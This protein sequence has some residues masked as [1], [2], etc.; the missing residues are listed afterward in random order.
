MDVDVYFSDFLCAADP[1]IP[2][3]ASSPIGE[4]SPMALSPP[5]RPYEFLVAR[6][7]WIDHK[8]LIFF[9]VVSAA[10]CTDHHFEVDQRCDPSDSSEREEPL[11]LP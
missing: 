2:G 5:I 9:P 7:L 4:T 10:T 11:E 1:E 6:D 3:Q 8:K